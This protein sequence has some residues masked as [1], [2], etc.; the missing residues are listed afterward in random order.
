VSLN[1][2]GSIPRPVTVDEFHTFQQRRLAAWPDTMNATST[3]DTKRSED[4]RARINVISEIPAEWERLA[5]RWSRW[6]ADKRGEVTRNEEYLLYQVLLGAWPLRDDEVPAFRDR[7]KGY[8]VKAA[9]EAR[10]LTS[11]LYPS[12][13]HEQA[14]SAFVDALFDDGRFLESFRSMAEKLAFYGAMNSLSQVLLKITSPGVPDFYQ[15]TVDWDFSLV[16]PDNRRPVKWP[17]LTDFA[18]KARDF[19]EHWRDGQVKVFLTERA[20]GFRKAHPDLFARGEY[21]PLTA[22]GKRMANIIG[23]ARRSGEDWALV[24]APRLL[25]QLSIVVR[26]PIGMRAWRDTAIALPEGAPARWRNVITGEP[27]TSQDGQLSLYRALDHFPVAL[28]SAR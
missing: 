15:G 20:L 11:W 25:T 18:E 13:R 19:L 24:L 4:V 2:V 16:D 17:D 27:I 22:Q 26:P 6:M 9:R 28:L 23:F 10:T 1:E 7:L 3:H 14:L 8:M 21:I 5:A 12:D